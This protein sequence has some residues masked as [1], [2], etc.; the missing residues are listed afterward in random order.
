[1]FCQAGQLQQVQSGPPGQAPSHA[2][3][4]THQGFA[5]PGVQAQACLGPSTRLFE[6]RRVPDRLFSIQRSTHL[7]CRPDL[8]TQ[9]CLQKTDLCRIEI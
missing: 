7:N 3:G 1:M 4:V 9:T 2:P 6:A 8:G 5:A